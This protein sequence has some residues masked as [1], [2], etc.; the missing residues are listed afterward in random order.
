MAEQWRRCRETHGKALGDSLRAVALL[1]GLLVWAGLPRASFVDANGTQID[2]AVRTAIAR[3]SARV[4]VEL[5]LA[6][7]FRPEGDLRDP[8]AVSAQRSAI[9]AAQAEMLS[10]LQGYH[11]RLIHQYGSVPLL[12]L[13]IGSDALAVLETSS[14]LVAR[15]TEDATRMPMSPQAPQ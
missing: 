7:A 5:R 15:V 12:A 11:F 9:A 14:D 13:E 4:I 2:P 6:P 3:G 8:S 10:R 1:L